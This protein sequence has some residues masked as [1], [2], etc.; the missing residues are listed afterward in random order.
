MPSPAPAASGGHERERV[1]VR[2]DDAA[3]ERVRAAAAARGI[4]LDELLFELLQAATW[5]I[6]DLLGQK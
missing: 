6:D 5:R 3:V 1:R 4:E 2:L